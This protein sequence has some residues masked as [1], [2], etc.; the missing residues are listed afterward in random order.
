MT[1]PPTNTNGTSSGCSRLATIRI[2][3]REVGMA[4]TISQFHFRK[5]PLSGAAEF[6]K[7][8]FF[9]LDGHIPVFRQQGQWLNCRIQSKQ[10]KA[11]IDLRKSPSF[12]GNAV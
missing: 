3:S 12:E 4:Q 7:V 5:F 1:A 10:L 8:H 11:R 6:T 2:S 9:S